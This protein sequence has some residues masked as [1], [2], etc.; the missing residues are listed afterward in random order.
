M[1]Y[2]NRILVGTALA[3]SLAVGLGGCDDGKSKR[4]SGS[5]GGGNLNLPVG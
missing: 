3:V 1:S 4:E 2:L 5:R